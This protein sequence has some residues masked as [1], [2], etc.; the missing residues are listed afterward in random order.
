MVS[1]KNTW[2][3][4]AYNCNFKLGRLVFLRV[5]FIDVSLKVF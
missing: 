4:K 5:D 1:I 3:D 2:K